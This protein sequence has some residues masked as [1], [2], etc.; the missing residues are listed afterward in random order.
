M[1]QRGVI[2]DPV[3]AV[4]R[5]SRNSNDISSF[6]RCE[7][8]NSGKKTVNKENLEKWD[9]KDQSRKSVQQ[10]LSQEE[11]RVRINVWWGKT[12]ISRK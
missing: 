3:E 2:P 12:W 7:Q 8:D 4:T 5:M 11:I 1:G 6:Q 9:W 10:N